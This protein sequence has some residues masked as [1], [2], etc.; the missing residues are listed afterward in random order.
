MTLAIFMKERGIKLKTI[1]LAEAGRVLFERWAPRMNDNFW[2]N[3]RL[4]DERTHA[5]FAERYATWFPHMRTSTFLYALWV[6][7]TLLT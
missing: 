6:S 3:S 4:G 2:N 5:N 1:H 7:F